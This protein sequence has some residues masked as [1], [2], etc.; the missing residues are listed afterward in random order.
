VVGQIHKTTEVVLLSGEKDDIAPT[1]YSVE[2][3]HALQAAGIK[4]S[5]VRVPGEGH[6]ILL[7]ESVIAAIKTMIGQ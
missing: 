6:E 7:H 1:K 3:Y 5:L 2:Y 4:S